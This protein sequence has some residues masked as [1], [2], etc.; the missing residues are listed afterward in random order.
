MLR[1]GT[2]TIFNRSIIVSGASKSRS[3]N[4]STFSKLFSFPKG[5]GKFYPKSGAG[6]KQSES[7][8]ESAAKQATNKSHGGSSNNN[9][10]KKPDF[11]MQLIV[12]LLLAGAIA[13]S[14]ALSFDKKSDR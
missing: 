8:A 3:F 14:Y 10:G 4:N 9:D 13:T 12:Q 5:F 11:N 1:H 7:T 6:S 2:K